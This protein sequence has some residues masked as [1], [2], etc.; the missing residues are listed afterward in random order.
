MHKR[1]IKGEQKLFDV[2]SGIGNYLDIDPTIIRILFAVAAVFFGTGILLYLILA[3][4][5][6]SR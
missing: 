1:L 4:V 2:C 6:P 3:V 5:M